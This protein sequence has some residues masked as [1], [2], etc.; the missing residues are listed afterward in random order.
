LFSWNVSS[1]DTGK[2]L[3]VCKSSFPTNPPNGELFSWDDLYKLI[4]LDEN[5]RISCNKK[6]VLAFCADSGNDAIMTRHKKVGSV[7]NSGWW[8]NL[9]HYASQVEIRDF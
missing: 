9:F 3:W 2:N 8:T 6:S 5:K 7:F 4:V 1:V